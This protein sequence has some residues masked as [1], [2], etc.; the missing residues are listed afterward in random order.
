[1]NDC[2]FCKIINGEI[3]SSKVYEDNE[4]IAF[5]DIMPTNPGHTLVV[6]KK[7][8]KDIFEIDEDLLGKLAIAVKKIAKAV[9]QATKATSFNLIL[10][11]GATAG[12]VIPH[13]HFH[14]VPRHEKDGYHHWKGKEY[15]EGEMRAMAEKIKNL[16]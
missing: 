8:G 12:Q 14:I 9:M 7:H 11:N 4:I 5:L 16:L 15:A 1:M 10:N 3:P 13:F 6:P 2:L